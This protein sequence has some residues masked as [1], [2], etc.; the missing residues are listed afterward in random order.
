MYTQKRLIIHRYSKWMPN[1]TATFSDLIFVYACMHA[2]MHAGM[3]VCVRVCIYGWMY[4]CMYYLC[5][6]VCVY[7]CMY[8]YVYVCMHELRSCKCIC[9]YTQI[10]KQA[11]VCEFK[12]TYFYDTQ[13]H[14]CVCLFPA[15]TFEFHLDNISSFVYLHRTHNP[16][17]PQPLSCINPRDNQHTLPLSSILLHTA[18]IPSKSEKGTARTPSNKSCKCLPTAILPHAP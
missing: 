16:N 18:L 6:Y 3:F 9:T 12:Y 17:I 8:V 14:M 4:V 7:A 1:N 2:C 15:C 5:L 11:G 13:T 10:W